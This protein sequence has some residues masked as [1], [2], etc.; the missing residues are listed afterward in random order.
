MGDTMKD[1]LVP[2]GSAAEAPRAAERAIAL[3]GA[4]SA[5]VHLLNVQRPLPRHVSRF[6]PRSELQAFHHEAGMAVL[7]PAARALDA[8]G[9]PHDEHVIVGHAAEAIVEF[10]ERHHCADIV[11]DTA[12][13]GLL[14]ILHAGSIG[15]QVRHLMRTQADAASAAQAIP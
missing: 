3:Y 11:L 7:A 15:S 6:F 1:I 4:E 14:S 9:V 8:A 2:I 5:R 12:S 13:K 10:A